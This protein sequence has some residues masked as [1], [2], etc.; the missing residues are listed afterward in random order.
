MIDIGISQEDTRDR[1]VTGGILAGLQ[2]W[3]AFDLSRQIRRGIDQEPAFGGVGA[4]KGDARLRL[5]GNFPGT[6]GDAICA[7]TIPLWEAAAGCAP[8]NTDA[9]RSTLARSDRAGVAGA[10]E[11]NRQGF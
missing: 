7:G 8:K 3:R 4:A 6:S 2:L 1:A 9:N 10:L 5:R 11:K